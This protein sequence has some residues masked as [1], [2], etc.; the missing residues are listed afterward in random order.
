MRGAGR[1][2][3]ERA[4]G[5][6]GRGCAF[7]ERRGC[8]WRNRVVLTHA[9][10]EREG[11]FCRRMSTVRNLKLIPPASLQGALATKQSICQPVPLCN[12]LLRGA[13]HR[14]RIRA[15]RWLAMAL[16][17]LKPYSYFRTRSPDEALANSRTTASFI[18]GLRHWTARRAD[19]LPPSG[20]RRNFIL[21]A[22]LLLTH[23][24]LIVIRSVLNLV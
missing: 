9:P 19:P 16:I 2:R 20:L 22:A 4:V 12:G 23:N 5:C 15:T 10:R 13:C 17:G 8:G 21:H 1:D 14:A 6:G 11:V 3:H 24:R 18:P 7:D